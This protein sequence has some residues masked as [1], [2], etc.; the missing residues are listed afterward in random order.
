[1]VFTLEGI[2][3]LNIT[4][5]KPHQAAQL[6]GRAATTRQAIG[7]PHQSLEQADADRDIAAIVVRIGEAAF[8][9]AYDK[10][11]AMSLEEAVGY[12]LDGE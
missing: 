8:Q 12:A 9:E 10:G 3:S 11:R 1:M 5:G 4:V 6:I 2:A 7:E